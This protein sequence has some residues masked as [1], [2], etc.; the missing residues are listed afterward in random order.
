MALESLSETENRFKGTISFPSYLPVDPF[1]ELK[2]AQLV[3]VPRNSLS[4]Y[5]TSSYCFINLCS[6]AFELNII[7][8][9]SRMKFNTAELLKA[10]NALFILN[11][12][13]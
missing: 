3:T 5:S 11:A 8:V 9:C 1:S 2:G 4:F 12:S 6:Q 7:W 10:E 13:L